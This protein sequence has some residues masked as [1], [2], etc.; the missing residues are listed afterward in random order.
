MT[1]AILGHPRLVPIDPATLQELGV[2]RSMV[3]YNRHTEAP[4]PGGLFDPAIFSDGRFGRIV[5]P[6]AVT[7]PLVGPVTELPVLPIALRPI[8]K[9]DGE[10]IMS[11]LNTAYQ[12]VLR[13]EGRL[14]RLGELGVAESIVAGAREP[15]AQA[16]AGLIGA[17]RASLRPDEDSACAALDEATIATLYAMGLTLRA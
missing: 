9:R 16:V 17:L 1:S 14:R 5:L 13:H 10:W 6:E 4:E 15:L 7:H 3:T 2:V 11:S 12:E 8:A